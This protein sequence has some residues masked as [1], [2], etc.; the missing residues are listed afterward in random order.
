MFIAP[1]GLVVSAVPRIAGKSES[2]AP[3]DPVPSKWS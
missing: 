1:L 3:A 2:T